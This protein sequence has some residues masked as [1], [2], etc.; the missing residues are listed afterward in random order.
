[1]PPEQEKVPFG[2]A[3]LAMFSNGRLWAVYFCQ[4]MMNL[5]MEC[6]ALLPLYLQVSRYI[7]VY[8]AVTAVIR[9]FFGG[10]KFVT[11]APYAPTRLT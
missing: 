2:K 7:F 5:A 9:P 10:L 6:Q 4:T 1:M 8:T 11:N 3:M